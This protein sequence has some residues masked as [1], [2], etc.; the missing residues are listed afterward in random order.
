MIGMI[1]K[2]FEVLGKLTVPVRGVRGIE[3]VIVTG[4]DDGK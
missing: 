4:S 2:V 3:E 1:P